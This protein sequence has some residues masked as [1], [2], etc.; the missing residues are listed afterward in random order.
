MVGA[1]FISS[2]LGVCF[3]VAYGRL[4]KSMHIRAHN[5][6]SIDKQDMNPRQVFIA[7]FLNYILRITL[8]FASLVILMSSVAINYTYFLTLF[9][10]CFIG[11]IC[12][13][14]KA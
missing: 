6:S 13:K 2:V 8:L 7:L 1:V 10:L 11:S 5:K 3:G 12:I 14:V 4:F 9:F